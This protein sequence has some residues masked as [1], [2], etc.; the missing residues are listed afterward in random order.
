M[1]SAKEIREITGAKI[2]I[3]E[4][5]RINLEQGIFNWPN[6]VNAWGKISH[7]LFSPLLKNR[8]TF[9]GV[10]ADIILDEK[11]LSLK[12]YGLSGRILHTP[13]HTM[14]S[15][16]VLLDSGEAF[17]GCMAH[18]NLPFRFCP[19]LPIYADNI[20]LIKQSWKRIIEEGATMIFPGHGKPFPIENIKKYL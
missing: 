4:N 19:G 6:G 8:M 10:K 15:V 12:D 9:P 7:G 5:D 17:V 16:S 14:G 18:N 13:G 20:E 3:H 11:G 1:G 2:A